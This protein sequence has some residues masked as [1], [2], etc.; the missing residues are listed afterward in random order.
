MSPAAARPTVVIEGPLGSCFRN[1]LD[2]LADCI[3]GK[4]S[5]T[6]PPFVK[7]EHDEAAR[8]AYVMVEDREVKKQREMWGMASFVSSRA[9]VLIL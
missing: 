8:K 5:M 7:L 3:S 4:M 6:I 1:L 9:N 2:D